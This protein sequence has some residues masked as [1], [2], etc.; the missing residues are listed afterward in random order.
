MTKSLFI[1]NSNY[2]ELLQSGELE[3]QNIKFPVNENG[4]VLVFIHCDKNDNG[5]SAN[6]SVFFDFNHKLNARSLTEDLATIYAINI[7]VKFGVKKLCLGTKSK[8]I[9]EK[10]RLWVLDKNRNF[11]EYG[12]KVRQYSEFVEID[13]L[14]DQIE[15]E[16]VDAGG[17]VYPWLDKD[18]FLKKMTR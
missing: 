11:N 3:I 10:F 2:P 8:F 17:F 15:I 9:I 7:A 14:L 4:Y 13:R 5:F 16:W 1:N 12:S 6:D 18:I